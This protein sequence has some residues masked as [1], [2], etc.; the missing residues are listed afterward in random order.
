MVE[1]SELDWIA[2]KACELLEDKVKD[3]PLADRD[4]KLA[5]EIFAEPRLQKLSDAFASELERRQA[6][7]RIMMK[8]QERARQLNADHWRKESP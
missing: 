7:D 6:I 4:V 8:L 5:F 3:A 1:P 2:Q